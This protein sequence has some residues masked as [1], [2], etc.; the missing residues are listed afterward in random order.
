MF[1]IAHF[2]ALAEGRKTVCS[3]SFSY[4]KT[5]YYG[6]AR[7]K[8]RIGSRLLAAVAAAVQRATMAQKVNERLVFLLLLSIYYSA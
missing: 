1:E 3:L 2:L 4:K 8:Q 5:H 7:L 6:A